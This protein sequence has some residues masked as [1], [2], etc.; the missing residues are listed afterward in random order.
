MASDSQ[1]HPAPDLGDSPV[2]FLLGED[3]ALPTGMPGHA[4]SDPHVIVLFGAT[5]DLAKR[6]LLPGLF[7]LSRAGMLPDCHIVATSLELL[8][9]G[10]YHAIARRACDEFAR[11]EITDEH[12]GAFQRRIVYVPGE[13]GVRCAT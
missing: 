8:D 11:V 3:R 9:D 2:A 10:G 5:G 7:H 1:D 12:W 4:P 6:K 13:H